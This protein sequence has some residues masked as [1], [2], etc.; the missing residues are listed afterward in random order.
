MKTD[1]KIKFNVALQPQRPY[2]LFRDGEPRA[3]TSTFTQL[4]S[5]ELWNA[6]IYWDI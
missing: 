2:G 3:A 5:S 1:A 4:M 6:G